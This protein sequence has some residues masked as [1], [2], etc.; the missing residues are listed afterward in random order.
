LAG[1][2]LDDLAEL[3]GATWRVLPD[4][5]IWW[6]EESWPASTAAPESYTVVDQRP[7]W[8]LVLAA[9]VDALVAL[10]GQTW[11]G[12]RVGAAVYS[13]EPGASTLRAYYQDDAVSDPL[14]AGLRAIVRQELR[15]VDYLAVYPSKVVQQRADG[16][17]DLS[18]DSPRVPPMTSVRLKVPAP[19]ARISCK[20]GDRTWLGFE[21]GD[22]RLPYAWSWEQGSSGKAVARVDDTAAAGTLIFT[23]VAN[24]VLTG[25]YTPPGGTPTPFALNQNITLR[26][27]IDSGSPHLSLPAGSSV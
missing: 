21:G 10:P 13:I 8:G 17:L 18:P 12:G 4:G 7:E 9:A 25:T 20:A 5:S 1:Q 16:S 3:L 11:E 23:A 24:G 2:G 26:A 19:R 6:G 15:A 22:P 27:K 14:G